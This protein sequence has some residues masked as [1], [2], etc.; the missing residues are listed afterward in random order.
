MQRLSIQN[1]RFQVKKNLK[2]LVESH[3]DF[4]KTF[5]KKKKRKSHFGNIHDE[6]IYTGKYLKRSRKG[7]SGFF[8]EF[9]CK[10]IF[11]V[12]S[13][14]DLHLS[15]I[16]ISGYAVPHVTFKPDGDGE[17]NIEFHYGYQTPNSN[18]IIPWMKNDNGRYNNQEILNG[19]KN[20][21]NEKIQSV[22]VQRKDDAGNII[23]SYPFN[24]IGTI[25]RAPNTVT[26]NYGK[27]QKDRR[28]H[29]T[30]PRNALTPLNTNQVNKPPNQVKK[31]SNQ[32]NKVNKNPR[33]SGHFRPYN[34]H[35]PFS[36]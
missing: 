36:D 16:D 5:L 18:I 21:F 7:N 31:P 33:L 22:I 10:D 14:P 20:E 25:G 32:V 30:Q 35:D 27:F 15:I 9:P 4:L 28:R 24:P 17:G 11:K 19:L 34:P 12:G 6:F 13:R 3:V 1:R 26:K 8:Y 2:K 29:L 23:S